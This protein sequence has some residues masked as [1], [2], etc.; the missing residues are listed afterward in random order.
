M[1][2]TVSTNYFLVPQE[3]FPETSSYFALDAD[4]KLVPVYHVGKRSPGD[5]YEFISEL[6]NRVQGYFQLTTDGDGAQRLHLPGDA[7]QKP[8]H[9]R[10]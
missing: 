3:E 10:E 4:T 7:P 2:V 1:Q 8:P 6:A 5:A 9:H